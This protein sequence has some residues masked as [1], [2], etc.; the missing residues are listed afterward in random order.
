MKKVTIYFIVCCLLLG[1]GVLPVAADDYDFKNNEDKYYSLCSKSGLTAEEKTACKAFQAYLTEQA[2]DVQDKINDWNN[3]LDSIRKDINK[4][5]K[6]IGE[7]DAQIAKIEK[8]QDQLEKKI[9]IIE[10]EVASLQIEI[11]ARE[12]KIQTL[13][14][15][16]KGRMVNMQSIFSLNKYIEYL[17]GANDFVDLIRRTSA[18]NQLMEYDTEQMELLEHEKVLLQENVTELDTQKASLASQSQLLE[19]MKKEIQKSKEVQRKFYAEYLKKQAELEASKRENVSDLDDLQDKLNEISKALGSVAPSA[20]WIYPIDSGWYISAG[21]WYYPSSFGGGMHL[22]VDFAA[23]KKRHVVASANG[24][25]AYAYDGCTTGGLGNGCGGV[26]GAGNS[27]LLIVQVGS[28]TYGVWHCH[29]SKGLKVKKG[30]IVTQGTILGNV[31]STGNSSGP[32]THVEIY[33]LGTMSLQAALK[34]FARTGNVSFGTGWGTLKTT[35]DRKGPP[36][37]MNPQKIY[38]VKVGQRG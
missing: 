20:G 9:N 16:I 22:G 5:L 11:T 37:R 18:I 24:V 12:E 10:T 33:D 19:E 31:G 27:I 1:L 3:Q 30:D 28:R 21:A 36:C 8:Q 6:V 17:M 25:V 38:N 15:Q 29:M 13:D 14:E 35:C 34:E 26:W 2:K 23:S 7:L 4:V 32:H